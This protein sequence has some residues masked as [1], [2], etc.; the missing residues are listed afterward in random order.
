[1]KIIRI[2]I[3]L[4]FIFIFFGCSKLE[5]AYSFAPRFSTN[6]LD[7]Y[8]DF[9]S[10][11]YDKV[12]A[13][14][15]ADFKDNKILL[16]ESLLKRLDTLIALQDQKEISQEKMNEIIT[17]FRKLQPEIVEK[18]KPSLNEIIL[19]MTRDELKNI[20]EEMEERFAKNTESLNDIEKLKKRQMKNF[21][22]NMDTV[23][24]DVTEEQNKMY[25]EFIE[26]NQSLYKEQ[27]AFRISYFSLLESLFDKKPEMLAAAYKYYSGDESIKSKDLQEKQKVFLKNLSILFQKIWSSLTDK[28]RQEFKKTLSELKTEISELK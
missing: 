24:D 26:Q 21:D 16:K 20:K 3:C 15:E 6:F 23:F 2:A 19:N 1:M 8:F 12:K 22:K 28:Q 11:R 9:S 13:A 10:E 7:K 4:F 17:D 18:F 14:L 27:L 25:S 5:T